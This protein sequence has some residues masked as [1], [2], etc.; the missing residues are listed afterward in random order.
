MFKGEEA[1]DC[2]RQP[3]AGNRRP[4]L[5]PQKPV[6]P[7]AARDLLLLSQQIPRCARD[8]NPWH[9]LQHLPGPQPRFP[10]PESRSPI[11]ES[12]VPIPESRVPSPE[13]R[14]SKRSRLKPLLQGAARR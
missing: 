4:T 10:T 5:Q 8:D 11:P 7:S 3:A 14:P 1:K 13:S 6:I 2:F 12:R 9:C